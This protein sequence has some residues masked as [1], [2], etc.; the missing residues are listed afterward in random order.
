M[1]EAFPGRAGRPD[2]ETVISGHGMPTGDNTVVP[3]GT[4]PT[5]YVEHGRTIPDGLGNE[6][7]T[8]V[9]PIN[10]KYQY[11]PGQT[12]PDYW[13]QPP[14]TLGLQGNPWIVVGPAGSQGAV[15]L[16]SILKPGMGRI[17]LAFCRGT[18]KVTVNELLADNPIWRAPVA[19]RVAVPV[20]APGWNRGNARNTGDRD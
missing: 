1:R 10:E 14:G 11:Q 8:G 6:V 12:M 15:R 13:V 3:D 20:A 16:S 9:A 19:E 2:G 18:Q 5:F 7:E 4:I 17:H